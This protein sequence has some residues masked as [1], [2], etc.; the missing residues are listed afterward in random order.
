MAGRVAIDAVLAAQAPDEI[1]AR[2]RQAP[3]AAPHVRLALAQPADLRAD[4]LAGEA[5]QREALDLLVADQRIELRDLLGGANVHAVEDAGPQRASRLV[6]RQQARTDRADGHG[7]DVAA[8]ERRAVE[9]LPAQGAQS[10]CHQTPSA[11]CS[12][13]PGAGVAMPCGTTAVRS[14]SPAGV[15]SAALLL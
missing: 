9:Q 6:Q 14:T 13:W 4:G 12:T 10:R 3:R 5:H 1:G 7:R 8:A 15:T 2:G 11:S